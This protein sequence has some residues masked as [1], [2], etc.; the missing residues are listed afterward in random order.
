MRLRIV[1]EPHVPP[2]L[3]AR[4]EDVFGGYTL[5]SAAT[6][7]APAAP[8]ASTVAGERYD[9]TAGEADTTSTQ[10]WSRQEALWQ[11]KLSIGVAPRLRGGDVPPPTPNSA[12]PP[13]AVAARDDV[14]A[15]RVS[16]AAVLVPAYRYS[17]AAPASST[18]ETLSP[19]YVHSTLARIRDECSVLK[20][21]IGPT[22]A[23]DG[24]RGEAGATQLMDLLRSPSA[25]AEL[26]RR[27]GGAVVER[28]CGFHVC[29]LL[30]AELQRRRRRPWRTKPPA[31]TDEDLR[32][33]AQRVSDTTAALDAHHHVERA[34]YTMGPLV[35]TAAAVMECVRDVDATTAV[36]AGLHMD[37]VDAG[38]DALCRQTIENAELLQRNVA[39]LLRRLEEL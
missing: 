38:V 19:A 4:A 30:D 6:T 36:T 9:T 16:P 32:S 31:S 23:D 7:P 28:E 3:T 5:T 18:A 20:E 12:S 21:R 25:V 1:R 34:L 33:F 17:S 2:T 37:A 26:Q 8:A 11:L 15:P 14:A 13:P 24:G 22:A 29:E 27:A 35:E 39:A 10:P